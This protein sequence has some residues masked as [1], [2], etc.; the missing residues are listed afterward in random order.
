MNTQ[1]AAE[2]GF[3]F[4]KTPMAPETGDRVNVVPS[5]IHRPL[6]P[7]GHRSQ[8]GTRRWGASISCLPLPERNLPQKSARSLRGSDPNV[9]G[10]VVQGPFSPPTTSGPEGSR[11]A[12]PRGVHERRQRPTT[13]PRAAPASSRPTRPDPPTAVR[14]NQSRRS[15]T[16]PRRKWVWRHCGSAGPFPALGWPWELCVVARGWGGLFTRGGSRGEGILRALTDLGVRISPFEPSLLQ[17]SGLAHS[18]PV[19][20]A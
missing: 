10:R 6:P 20:P 19:S 4:F 8:S 16:R 15:T 18:S 7:I 9:T 2:P 5:R 12:A 17:M 3:W 1:D 11:R 14:L 13:E